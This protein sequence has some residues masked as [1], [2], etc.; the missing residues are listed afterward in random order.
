M[1]HAFLVSKARVKVIQV[2][3]TSP[4]IKIIPFYESLLNLRIFL[5]HALNGTENNQYLFI[6]VTTDL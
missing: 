5:A 1:T 2:I 6:F 4:N 3:E